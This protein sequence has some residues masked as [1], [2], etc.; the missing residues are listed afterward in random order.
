MSTV[1]VFKFPILTSPIYRCTNWVCLKTGG[2]GE[3]NG[4]WV[5]INRSH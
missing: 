1:S 4:M 5:L 3:C 2:T